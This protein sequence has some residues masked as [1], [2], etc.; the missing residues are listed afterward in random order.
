MNKK[1]TYLDFDISK[2]CKVKPRLCLAI[3]IQPGER[4]H[5]VVVYLTSIDVLRCVDQSNSSAS[6]S[7]KS[8]VRAIN[9][10]VKERE[11]EREREKVLE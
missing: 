6:F 4:N 8:G 11:R 2:W 3:L 7:A 9:K 10:S 1:I 5:S